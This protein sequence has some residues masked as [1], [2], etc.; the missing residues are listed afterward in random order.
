MKELS[1]QVSFYLRDINAKS[2]LLCGDSILLFETEEDAK[3]FMYEA[4]NHGLFNQEIDSQI[5]FEGKC[6]RYNPLEV[7]F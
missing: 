6:V 1:P 2:P 5:I 3:C 7:Y 4:A